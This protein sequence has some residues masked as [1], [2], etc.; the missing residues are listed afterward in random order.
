MAEST[1]VINQKMKKTHVTL[2]KD[3]ITTILNRD[4]NIQQIKE[5]EAHCQAVRF[6][7]ILK[8]ED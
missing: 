3:G 5:K 4:C 1:W 2:T 7:F 6:F 8:T